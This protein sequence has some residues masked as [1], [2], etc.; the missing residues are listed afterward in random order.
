MKMTVKYMGILLLAAGMLSMPAR[1]NAQDRKLERQE[2]KEARKAELY[3]NYNALGGILNSRRFVLEA[4][5]LSNRYGEKIVVSPTVNFIMVTSGRGVLQTG[6]LST[7][8]YNGVGGVT[9]EG[10]IGKYE[11]HNNPKSHSYFIRFSLNT[12]IGTYDVAMSV[13]AEGRARAEISGLTPG[14]IIYEGHLVPAENSRVYKGSAV[15]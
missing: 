13:N 2:K 14:R 6:I 5:N 1:I 8:G 4:F 7:L 15:I 10:T 3:A 11:V 12:A 9:A